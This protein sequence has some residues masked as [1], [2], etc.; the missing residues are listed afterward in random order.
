MKL[1]HWL[2]ILGPTVALL[3]VIGTTSPKD[4]YKVQDIPEKVSQHGPDKVSQHDAAM[5][6]GDGPS[7]GAAPVDPQPAAGEPI[8]DAF[9]YV[10][11]WKDSPTSHEA[12]A[13]PVA[14]PQAAS[15]KTQRQP[16]GIGE[17]DQPPATR[18]AGVVQQV[19]E[20]NQRD[21]QLHLWIHDGQD[22]E[23]EIS[24]APA[25]FLEYIG[26]PVQHNEPV[27][28]TGFVFDTQAG[29]QL[30]YVKKITIGAKVCRLRNDEGFAL[31]SSRLQ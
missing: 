19:S 8:M 23:M 17:L 2:V 27:S 12:V 26:C 28:G 22:K 1:I 24:L 18:F 7:P 25:W 29:D 16:A 11:P 4:F 31:W 30:V 9:R 13:T 10:T 6:N 21:G 3:A 14:L 20:F 5:V 15:P